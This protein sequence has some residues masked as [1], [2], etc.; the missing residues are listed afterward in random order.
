LGARWKFV[1]GLGAVAGVV[2]VGLMLVRSGGKGPVDTPPPAPPDQGSQ[3]PATPEPPSARKQTERRQPP[4]GTSETPAPVP[5]AA[6]NLIT[7]W[8][9][10][11]DEILGAEGEPEAK[12]KQMLGMF[13]SLPEE[14]QVEVAKHLSNLT[15]DEDYA[16]LAQLLANPKLPEEVLD[17]L[18]SDALNRPNSLKL[19]ALLD[20]VRA[21]QHPKAADAKE[22][23]EFFLEGD[24]G[25]DW[26]KWQEK[27]QEWLKENPD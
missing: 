9:D 2:I 10:K 3:T 16:S 27:I 15:P 20:V 17:T 18:M 11:V 6:S 13:P 24:Y 5:A 4:V 26:P 19:P 23:L 8:D 22:V 25:D 1:V 12:A 21:T 7:N 14:G